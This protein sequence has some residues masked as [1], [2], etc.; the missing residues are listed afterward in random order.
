MDKPGIET[1]STMP[2]KLKDKNDRGWKAFHLK[3]Q[4]GFDPEIIVVSKV[5]GKN[6][7][8]MLHAL[9]PQNGNK[10]KLKD[11]NVSLLPEQPLKL[12]TQSNKSENTTKNKLSGTK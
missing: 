8:I 6:N 9:V 11:T 1:V 4:F 10:P 7:I 5:K 12:I 3:S 2:F